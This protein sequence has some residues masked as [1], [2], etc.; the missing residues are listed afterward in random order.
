[1]LLEIVRHLDRSQYLV[2][3]YLSRNFV[4]ASLVRLDF[5][6][7][8]FERFLFASL[9]FMGHTAW[10]LISEM[11]LRAGHGPISFLAFAKYIFLFPVHP[12]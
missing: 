8:A 4:R 3:V 2:A 9:G 11:L 7:L 12:G 6:K 5:F 1:M 10:L